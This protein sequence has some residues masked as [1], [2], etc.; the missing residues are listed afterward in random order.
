METKNEKC[1]KRK[2]SFLNSEQA[3]ETDYK[4]AAADI[5]KFV[6]RHKAQYKNMDISRLQDLGSFDYY[7]EPT[8]KIL[9]DLDPLS[10]LKIVVENIKKL[11]LRNKDRNKALN[12]LFHCFIGLS[13][14]SMVKYFLE[15]EI[16]PNGIDRFGETPIF[17]LFH[18]AY[19]H[20]EEIHLDIKCLKLLIEHNGNFNLKTGD[21]DNILF[22]LDDETF[23]ASCD[24]TKRSGVGNNYLSALAFL[25][26]N[27]AFDLISE[28]DLKDL[29]STDELAHFEAEMANFKQP[30]VLK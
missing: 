14:E 30:F 26:A 8:K 13:S 28:Q 15:E 3:S 20:P 5:L 19:H 12:A 9:K 10:V 17:T 1:T 18:L 23:S 11:E 22:N 16:D 2:Y 25:Y 7:Y 4:R 29:L 27:S 24:I 6:L 21:Y